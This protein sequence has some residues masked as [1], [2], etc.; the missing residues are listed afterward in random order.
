MK[1]TRC[2]A[3]RGPGWGSDSGKNQNLPWG[4]GGWFVRGRRK[5]REEDLDCQRRR[6]WDMIN[7]QRQQ[8]VPVREGLEVC[9]ALGIWWS[10]KILSKEIPGREEWGPGHT[11]VHVEGLG[12][13]E[14]GTVFLNQAQKCH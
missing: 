7:Q 14:A 4:E 12:G 5:T 3:C 13:E 2:G 8:S 6:L 9:P 10:L 1:R 11:A